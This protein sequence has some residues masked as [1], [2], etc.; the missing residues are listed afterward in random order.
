MLT[1]SLFQ[2]N[3]QTHV[4]FD[5][6]GRNQGFQDGAPHRFSIQTKV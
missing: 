6:L 3:D 4:I 5:V 1:L 2:K